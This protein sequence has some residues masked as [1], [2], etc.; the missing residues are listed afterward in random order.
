[1]SIN[2]AI[3]FRPTLSA[4][5]IEYLLNL[6]SKQTDPTAAEITTTLNK[7]YLKAKHGII[8]ASHVST[9]RP[10]LESSLGFAPD[11]SIENLLEIYNSNQRLLNPTQ[12]QKVQNHR[13]MND[14]MSPDEEYQ[15]EQSTSPTK[16][17]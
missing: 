11:P 14:L 1:M 2:P 10:S 16:D 17:L 8:G 7:F 5:E 4:P 12:L 13:Y 3:K 6:L 9:S 15:Y